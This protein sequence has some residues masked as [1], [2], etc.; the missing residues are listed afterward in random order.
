[1]TTEEL[2]ELISFGREQLGVEFKSPGSRDDR[3]FFALVARAMMG[4]VNRRDGGKVIIGVREDQNRNLVPEGL[5]EQQCATW[6]HDNLANSIDEYADPSVSFEVTCVLSNGKHFVAI[7]IREFEDVP[8][9]CKRT[10]S[11]TLRKGACYVRPRRKP[12]TTE[13]PSQAD[14]RDLLD[15]ATEKAL[16]KFLS[17]SA[18]AGFAYPQLTRSADADE[19]AKQIENFWS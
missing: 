6:P 5:S 8:I 12:E 10:Y 4:M 7:D 19:F 13:V 3:P 16:R 14:M 11:D 17:Q 2:E 15:L 1:M 18:K 9:L